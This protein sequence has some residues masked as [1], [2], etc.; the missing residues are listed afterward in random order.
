MHS[1]VYKGIKNGSFESIDVTRSKQQQNQ[2]TI[3]LQPLQ[4]DTLTAEWVATNLDAWEPG[5]MLVRLVH[6]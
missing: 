3:I 2:D 4:K 1:H 6:C 5:C